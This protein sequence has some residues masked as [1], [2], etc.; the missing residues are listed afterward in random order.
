MHWIVL[1]T[2]NSTVRAAALI[3]PWPPATCFAG[4]A[5]GETLPEIVA[6]FH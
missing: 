3:A 6:N 4:S 1:T 2:D 5:I